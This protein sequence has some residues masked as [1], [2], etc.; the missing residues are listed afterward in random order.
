MAQCQFVVLFFAPC[1]CP[2]DLLC[3]GFVVL[4]A[5][6]NSPSARFPSRF[7]DL[8]RHETRAA[9]ASVYLVGVLL[10]HLSRLLL[11]QLVCA[12]RFRAPGAATKDLLPLWRVIL[13]LSPNIIDLA[14]NIVRMLLLYTT[15]VV[16]SD[17]LVDGVLSKGDLVVFAAEMLYFYYNC[18]LLAAF[19][20]KIRNPYRDVLRVV[21]KDA[22]EDVRQMRASD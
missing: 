12:H 20:R 18:A 19:L 21:Y 16:R 10:K 1:S 4:A 14:A 5:V 22:T 11:L 9:L 15:N 8:V 3:G 17:A 2:T 13:F 6:Q 7:A